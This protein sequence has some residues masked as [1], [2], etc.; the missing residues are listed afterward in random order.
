M[1]TVDDIFEAL[2]GTSAFGRALGLRQSTASEMRRRKSIPVWHW[3]KLREAMQEA[4]KPIDF[5]TLVAIHTEKSNDPNGTH[6][7]SSD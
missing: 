5:E 2:G 7:P 1:Q 4:G 6:T 3:R